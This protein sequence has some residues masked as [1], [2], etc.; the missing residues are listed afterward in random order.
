MCIKDNINRLREL[1]DIDFPVPFRET[2]FGKEINDD[3][4]GKKAVMQYIHKDTDCAITIVDVE[5][6]FLH[7]SHFHQE[8]EVIVLLKG[9]AYRIFETGEEELVCNVPI[10]FF[11]NEPHTMYYEEV[12]KVLAITIPAS[13]HFPNP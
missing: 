13:R 2:I 11:P 3:N 4:S 12:S 10:V 1:N 9:K 6:G 5:A 7:K 8:C